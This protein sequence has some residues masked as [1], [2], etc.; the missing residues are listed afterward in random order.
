MKR[1]FFSSFTETNR[2][3][4]MCCGIFG[5]CALEYLTMKI[6]QATFNERSQNYARQPH[7]LAHWIWYCRSF[8]HII[9]FCSKHNWISYSNLS[10]GK[11]AKKHI[12]LSHF[13]CMVSY[14]MCE[15]V[16]VCSLLLLF[17]F[18]SGSF[19]ILCIRCVFFFA[20]L[21]R[22]SCIYFA[23]LLLID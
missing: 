20:S 16:C 15:C 19:I 13:M 6:R 10:N 2:S 18:F 7:L 3:T 21:G 1:C 22:I 4:K 11:S 12:S 9:R 8:H 17:V 5:I 14:A 23:L